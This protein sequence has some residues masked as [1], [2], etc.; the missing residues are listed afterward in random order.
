M[1]SAGC[2]FLYK[3]KYL[4]I[5]HSWI[6]RNSPDIPRI[7]APL[8]EWAANGLLTFV[9]G[10]EVAPSI[11]AQWLAEQAQIYNMTCIGIDS[12]RFTL[13]NKALKEAG[14]DTDRD[15]ANNIRLTKRVTIMRYA[16]VIISAFAR[17]AVAWGKNPLMNWF[18]NNAYRVQ[19]RDGNI[20]FQKKEA[21]SRK[22]DGFFAFVHAVCASENLED[23]GEA[24][25]FESFF[26]NFKVY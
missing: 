21:K 19:D 25:E 1:I 14:F 13:L 23:C 9:D 8:E 2:L 18:I 26:A 3:G 7:K 11:P 20:I 5:T 22:T 16:P 12:F 4:W 15:G 17:Q 24:D 10:P 6:C